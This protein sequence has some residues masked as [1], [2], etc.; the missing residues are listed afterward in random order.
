[1]SI[2]VEVILIM[3]LSMILKRNSWVIF[4]RKGFIKKIY[5]SMLINNLVLNIEVKNKTF[6]ELLFQHLVT[7][8]WH[9]S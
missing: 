8:F 3:E 5:K 1:M 4:I 9:V 2:K 6:Q 7:I